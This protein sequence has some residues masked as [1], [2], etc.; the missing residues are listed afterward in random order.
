MIIKDVSFNPIQANVL[1]LTLR[2]KCPNLEFFW[3]VFSPNG[4]FSC[5][6]I[7]LKISDFLTFSGRID[8]EHWPEMG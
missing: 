8:I 3:S 1:S 6:V 4:Q 2:E 7:Q 5:R